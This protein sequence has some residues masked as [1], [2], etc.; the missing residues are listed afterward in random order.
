MRGSGVQWSPPLSRR[1]VMRACTSASIGSTS[2]AMKSRTR[3]W[4]S[5]AR[6]EREKSMG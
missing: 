1:S 4:R 3:V 6:G 2:A 5:L